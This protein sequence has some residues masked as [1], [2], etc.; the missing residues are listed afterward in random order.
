M[1]PWSDTNRFSQTGYSAKTLFPRKENYIDIRIYLAD[2]ALAT[3]RE[4]SHV[5]WLWEEYQEANLEY[6]I[7]QAET[8]ALREDH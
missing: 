8:K 6:K 4:E 7:Q 5:D 1:E 3:T 2:L